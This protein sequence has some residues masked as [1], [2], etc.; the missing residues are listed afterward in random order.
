MSWTILDRH[1]AVLLAMTHDSIFLFVSF[2][3]HV[4]YNHSLAVTKPL[5]ERYIRKLTSHRKKVGEN[6][7]RGGEMLSLQ[8]ETDIKRI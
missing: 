4:S 8:T 2:V 5:D 6:F 7:V 3:P 1:V